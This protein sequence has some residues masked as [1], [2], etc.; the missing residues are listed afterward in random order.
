MGGAGGK[1]EHTPAAMP[2]SFGVVN[3]ELR[4]ERAEVEWAE[5]GQGRLALVVRS[6][7]GLEQPAG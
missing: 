2:S 6:A 3:V 4:S 1:L 5:R 7:V